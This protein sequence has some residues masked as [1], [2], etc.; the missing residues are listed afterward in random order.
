MILCIVHYVKYI[1]FVILIT[2]RNYIISSLFIILISATVYT[3]IK[4]IKP[5]G[6]IKQEPEIQDFPK[7]YESLKY[8][9]SIYLPKKYTIDED[10]K[11]A[12]MPDNSISGVSFAIEEDDYKGTNLSKDS[13]I[14]V[15]NISDT[16]IS[17]AVESFLDNVIYSG[18]I[19]EQDNHI[20]AVASSTDAG[21]G[22]RYEQ[23]VYVTPV[24]GGCSAIRYFIH[25]GA[26]ENYPIDT[27]KEFDRQKLLNKFDAIRKSIKYE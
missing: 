24:E 5:E 16:N 1:N 9:F 21:A 11:Y 20:F 26:F 12:F 3:F 23:T 13:F 2:M 6:I 22:N 27:I 15:E 4:D 17:C 18:I 19:E 7:L 10:Y 14:S 8:K 25:Y